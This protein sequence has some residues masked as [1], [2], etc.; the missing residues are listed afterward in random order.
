MEKGKFDKVQIASVEETLKQNVPFSEKY[1]QLQVMAAKRRRQDPQLDIIFSKEKICTD[2]IDPVAILE[3]NK[4]PDVSTKFRK[5]LQVA[6]AS[7]DS[8][9]IKDD[10][11]Y[12]FRG[13][14]NT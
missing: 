3:R 13:D 4:L 9:Y 1:K 14:L 7:V 5:Q 10:Y 6:I 2:D 11:A 8:K 12:V